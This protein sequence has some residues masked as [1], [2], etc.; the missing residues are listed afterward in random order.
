MTTILP[1]IKGKPEPTLR[2]LQR[3]PQLVAQ[4]LLEAEQLLQEA[5]Q[6]IQPI[7]IQAR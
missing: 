5:A 3:P 7:R 4:L 2:L 1:P 6:Q